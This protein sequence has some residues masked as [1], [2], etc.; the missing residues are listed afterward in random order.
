MTARFKNRVVRVST[1]RK[2]LITLLVSVVLAGG[3]LVGCS[4]DDDDPEVIIDVEDGDEVVDGSGDGL[5]ENDDENVMDP[6]PASSSDLSGVD[7]F[8]PEEGSVFSE[9]IV[10]AAHPLA[11]A[12]G[13]KVL[14]DGGN[15]VD[16]A[17]VTQFVLNVVEPTSSGIGGGGFMGIYKPDEGRVFYIDSR[18]KAPAAATPTQFLNCDPECTG[19]ETSE[20]RIGSF[21]EYATS[22]IGVGV[23]GTLLGA[24]QALEKYGSGSVTLAEALAP[25]IELAENGFNI[26]ERLAMLTESPRTTF[27]PATRAKFRTAE[28]EPLSEGF[29]LVQ[30]DL[31]K[32]FKLIAEQGVDV[33]Y[34]GEISDAI[35]NAQLVSRAEVGAPGAGRMT[36]ADLAAYLADFRN[37]GID[38]RQPVV[39]KYRGYTINGMPPPSSGG[40]TVAQIL[41][42][43]EQFP[44]GREDS[45]F[46]EGSVNTL[47]VMA[48]SM[49]LAFSSRGVWMGDNDNLP[50]PI[51]GLLSPEYLAERCSLINTDARIAE[52]DVVP[53]DPRLFDPAFAVNN[54][55]QVG[56]AEE[57]EVGIDTT[58]FTV[59][60]ANG[61][62]VSW[63]STIEGTW[64]S[65]I[66]VPGYGFLLNNELTDFNSVPQANDSEENFAP[67]AN[68]VAPNKRPRSSMAPT[69]VL[70]DGAFV[71]AYGSPGGSTIINSVVNMTV[72]LIDHGMTVQ[73]AIDAPR[74]SGGFGTV[75]YEEGFTEETLAGLRALGHN[76][77]DEPSDGIGSVQAVTV[78]ASTG[79]VSGGA[80]GR[81]AGTVEGLP[82]P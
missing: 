63:T 11:A 34:T 67:G 65:G 29:M 20:D 2:R 66:T 5:D 8:A 74:I 6:P 25:A 4:S 12:A 21:L 59:I 18:E 35:V 82:R 78:Q 19:E 23:P 17:V 40:L 75:S 81:R 30:P 14:E 41:A 47:H 49:L 64:G 62:V 39:S 3:L 24:A 22:G 33:F 9:G 79:L 58:H 76:L 46:G 53:G 48:E 28:N 36:K 43:I 16:A 31:A 71:A 42:C 57:G 26:N 32:T 50:L 68:D 7:E 80:D 56:T 61:L 55:S 13:I 73:E 37:G 27:W 44:I 1:P 54:G 52:E 45:G 69:L 70:N 15:A 51:D 38:E 77:R 72:N 10:S 60:D